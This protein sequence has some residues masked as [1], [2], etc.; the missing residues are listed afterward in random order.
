MKLKKWQAFLINGIIL[1]LKKEISLCRFTTEIKY[2]NLHSINVQ[3]KFWK[4]EME[5]IKMHLVLLE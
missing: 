2:K 5:I 3:N 4:R 1:K